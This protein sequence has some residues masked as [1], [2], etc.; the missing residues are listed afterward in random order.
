MNTGSI[1]KSKINFEEEKVWLNLQSQNPS[2]YQIESLIFHS[3]SYFSFWYNRKL[4]RGDSGSFR[5]RRVFSFIFLLSKLQTFISS[6]RKVNRNGN[7]TIKVGN[8][9]NRKNGH[10]FFRTYH[11][12]GGGVKV[13]PPVRGGFRSL[14]D[15]LQV[16]DVLDRAS[17]DFY[18]GQ[19]L[20]GIV[21]RSTFQKLEGFVNLTIELHP[22]Q[23]EKSHLNANQIF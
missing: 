22:V 13:A 15:F 3:K 18:F 14:E 19:S 10:E 20:A 2:C 5:V 7:R 9:S 16:F 11:I 4:A 17:Q 21:A 8:K 12:F 6:V 23:F 1:W